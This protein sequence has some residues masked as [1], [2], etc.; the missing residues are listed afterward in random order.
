MAARSQ[1]LNKAAR[2]VAISRWRINAI[3]IVAVVAIAVVAL[4]LGN[5]QIV[6]SA[7]LTSMARSEI[8]RQLP[9]NPRRG[10]INVPRNVRNGR[11]NNRNPSWPAVVQRGVNTT[12]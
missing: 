9:L 10:T 5:L 3:L 2:P 6:Q 11:S 1:Q 7:K 4:R 12:N 8:K